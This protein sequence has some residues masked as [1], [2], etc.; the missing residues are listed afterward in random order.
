MEK[1]KAIFIKRMA[2]NLID[3]YG[4]E[5]AHTR[6]HEMKNLVCEYQQSGLDV[7]DCIWV[8]S[9]VDSTILQWKS[10]Q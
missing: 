8:L 4:K 1:D 5:E 6:V 3:K 9:F 10:Q 7:G 2:M